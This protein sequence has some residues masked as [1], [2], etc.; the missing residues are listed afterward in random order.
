MKLTKTKL[1]LGGILI[2]A[3]LLR[4]VALDKVPV[5]LFGDELDVGYQA[6]SILKT[7]KDYYGNFLPIHFHSLADY[8]T[9]LYLYA[10]VP[11]VAIF[12]ISP[13]G[14]RLPAAI[15]GVAGIFFLY[16][17]VKRV[18]RS[19]SLALWAAFLLTVS[20]WHIQYS[21]AA[22]EVTQLLFLYIAGIYFFIVG[23][24]KPK[25]LALSAVLLGLTPW[26][27]NTAKLFL[28][29][30]LVAI[31][32]IWRRELLAIPKKALAPA[33][34]C[35]VLVVTPFF[36]STVFGGGT[37]RFSYLSISSD[38]TIEGTIGFAR[39]TD[40]QLGFGK[41]GRLAHN[42]VLS[43]SEE[44]FNNY[45]QSFSS[46]FLFISG[47]VSNSRQS[48]QR[49]GEFY[50]FEIVFLI[51]G[52]MC[53]SSKI[54]DKRFKAFLV[55]WILASPIPS[56][57]T[58][59]GGDHATRLILMLPA[60]VILM[61][62]GAVMTVKMIIE[63]WSK[64]LLGALG[65]LIG[66]SVLFYLHDYWIHYPWES[67]KLWDA[68]YQGAITSAVDAGAGYSKVIISDADEPSLIYFLGWSSFSPEEFQKTPTLIPDSLPGFGDT[69]RLNKYYFTP[70]GSGQDLY[71]LG[72]ILD[73][74]TLYLA[75]AKEIKLDL[76]KEPGRVPSDVKLLKAIPYPS[77]EGAFY[78]FTGTR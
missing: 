3:T 7:G 53:L 1:L 62:V 32:I 45:F 65:L 19:E 12:G 8:R 37:E 69:L 44:F 67:E 11:T 43:V 52:L 18:S 46:E 70:I 51:L 15:F 23:L 9:P 74:N 16:L 66:L 36:I 56:A 29:M 41:I 48:I 63:R 35:F 47:D 20:P 39:I 5:S 75:T 28:P 50:K 17:L 31:L 6:Y 54:F 57:L 25:W 58:V 72:S 61:S 24:K 64:I 78:L 59:G 60:L 27:Y 34:I 77:G 68:G 26:S 13:L 10:S 49:M 40:N 21:R 73:K 55:F 76:I 22:F 4:F 2:L 30:T 42:R 14:V 33:A 71:K 38:P